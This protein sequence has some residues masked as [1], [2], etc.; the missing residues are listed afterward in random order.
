MSNFEKY[1]G[2]YDL[3]YGSK[4][5]AGEVSYMIRIIRS[6]SPSAADVLELGTGTGRHGHL[7]AEHGFNVHG[8]DRSR[9]MDAI[10]RENAPQGCAGS[11]TCQVGDICAVRLDRSFDAVVALF[12]VVCYQISNEAL[13]ATFETAAA[14][15]RSGGLFL[16]DAWHGPAVR[17]QPPSVRTKTVSDAKRRVT[18][19]AMPLV[20]SDSNVVEVVYNLECED[21]NSGLIERF[22]ETHPMRFIFLEEVERLAGE[23][24]LRLVQ[25]EEFMTG[26]APSDATWSVLYALQLLSTQPTCA[27]PAGVSASFRTIT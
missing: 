10:A 27:K 6:W 5:Y 21:L 2:Y 13:R 18:R 9:E 1:A 17:A 3:L 11:F 14:H 23:T 15:L 4:D 26:V 8:I 25:M 12:H 24:G 22:S 19:N 7:L 16:F 20:R